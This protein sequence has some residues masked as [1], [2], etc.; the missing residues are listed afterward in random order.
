MIRGLMI[1]FIFLSGSV[2]AS[3]SLYSG[4]VK[5]IYTSPDGK[6]SEGRL[7]PT[8]EVKILEKKDGKVKVEIEGFMK[9]GVSSAV[10]F[11]TGKRILTAGLSKKAKF[12]I[13]V[14]STSKDK[15]GVQWS[16]VVLTAYTTDD[17]LTKDLSALYKNAEAM[18]KDN[19]SICHPAHPNNEYTS[20]QWPSMIKSMSNR[21]AMTKE[22]VY[23]V[24]Q[25]LQKHSKDIGDK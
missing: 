3:E 11:T 4:S 13:K 17:N 18:Y 6:R 5:D 14:I 2:F 15:D 24:T 20:N 23:L 10:Y 1:G 16:K 22:D 9:D 25:F 7:L 21:T 12:D 8:S 19:C